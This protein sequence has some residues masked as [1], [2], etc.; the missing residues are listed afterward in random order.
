MWGSQR[1]NWGLFLIWC[2]LLT[3]IGEVI[4]L[5]CHWMHEDGSE[6]LETI[7]QALNYPERT[8]KPVSVF[9]FEH[10]AGLSV[11]ERIRACR[12]QA[13]DARKLAALNNANQAAY[14]KIA[15]QWDSIAAEVEQTAA[16]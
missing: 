5:R 16:E 9:G 11:P 13:D 8:K 7:A 1:G 14:L 6:M 4:S 2:S 3:A 15:E 10:W 12:L